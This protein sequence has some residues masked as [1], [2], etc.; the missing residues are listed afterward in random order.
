MNFVSSQYLLFFAAVFGIYWCLGRRRQNLLILVSSCAFYAVW[1]WRL[2]GLIAISTV[3]NFVCGNRIA[4]STD[5]P[6]R[7]R[8]LWSALAI[9]LGILG[10]FKYAN[11]FADSLVSLAHALNFGVQPVTL[12]VVL[13]VGISFYVFH[14][15]SYTIDIY[16]GELRRSD[17]LVD[18]AAFVTFF[19]QMVA[20]PIVRAR[21]LLFQLEAERQ[22]TV[23]K[24]Q[25]GVG[26][27]ITGLFLKAFVADNLAL[28]LVDPVF[29]QPAAFGTA[30]LWWALLGYSFQIYAD[31]Y[32][33][34][35]M[36]TGSALLL[37]IQLPMN[38]RYPYLAIDFSDFWQRWHISMSRFFRDYVYIPLGGN[39]ATPRRQMLNL[40]ITNLLSGLWHGANWTFVAWGAQHAV[41]NA[42][43]QL[44]RRRLGQLSAASQRRWFRLTLLP[45]WALVQGAIMQTWVVF[46]SR[47]FAT[48][49][50]FYRG[51]F[52]WQD[53]QALQIGSLTLCCLLAVVADHAY[54]WVREHLGKPPALAVYYP[55][56]YTVMLLA[57]FNGM[58]A[59]ATPFIY[60]QF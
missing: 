24:V 32:G 37:G 59:H 34:T 5:G 22:L 10:T 12:Q 7:R 36:A 47:D 58:P 41:L 54:G 43:N 60:F 35:L 49:M 1:D 2:L 29:S 25:T 56:A 28:A 13:P 3:S 18:F 50:D 39:R 48:A 38:F 52:V 11:F 8:W 27:F 42:A 40:A 21:E 44:V 23:A 53:G 46:R 6:R 57:V 30:T 45:R 55:A 31:F 20:G 4:A 51:L 15:L 19:P 16:R 33:Y 9:N 17:S 14:S 26:M